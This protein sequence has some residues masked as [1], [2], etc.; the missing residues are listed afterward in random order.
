MIKKTTRIRFLLKNHA[1]WAVVRGKLSGKENFF[2]SNPE[3]LNRLMVKYFGLYKDFDCRNP[4]TFNEML[5][6]LKINYRNELWMQCADKLGS[7][8]FLKEHGFEKYVVRV[9]GRY[10]SS[11]EINLDE[12]PNDFVLKTNHDYGSVYVCHK[13]QTNFPEI[14]EKLDKAM[15]K[16]FSIN[17]GEWVYEKIK[18][19]IFAEEL[20]IPASGN[21]L[22]DYKFHCFN[23]K[24]GWGYV[25]EKRF[26]DMKY[27]IFEKG[28]EIQDVEWISFKSKIPPAKPVHYDEMELI[29]EKISKILDF[30]RV[31]FFET[32]EGPKIGELT[33][34]S[35]SG[36]GLFSKKEYDLRYGKMFDCCRLA[37]LLPN[38]D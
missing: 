33:F 18:P 35:G 19:T 13:G 36:R 22:L 32:S 28:Y 25:T 29:G 3:E 8:E 11:S 4:K 21:E 24:F 17:N 20:L 1:L 10:S 37:S 38:K 15:K 30:V 16:K 34:F 6:W 27:N 9:Y 2:S 14:F 12:L 7:K 23:G 5:A 26:T 31:D